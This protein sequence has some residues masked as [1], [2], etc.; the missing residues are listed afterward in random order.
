MVLDTHEPKKALGQHWLYDT[1]V[2][3]AMCDAVSLAPNDKVLEIGPGLG[4]LTAR[5]LQGGAEVLALEYDH[6]LALNLSKNTQKLLPKE[7]S[8]LLTRLEVV[9]G[10]IRSF[11]LT[12]IPF[13]Y[14]LC[15]NI[16]Y[17]LTSNLIRILCDTS[18]QPWEAA[19]LMQKEVAERIVADDG[20]MSIISCIA[21]FYYECYGGDTVPAE[22]FTPPPKVNSQVLIMRRR[23]APL[24]A[25]NTKQF[26]RLIKAGYSEKR[27]NVRNAL[28]G[29]LG[30]SREYVEEHLDQAGIA[31]SER[32]ENLSLADWKKLFDTGLVDQL[33]KSA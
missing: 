16:P 30:T 28:S 10:D 33:S 31:H 20:K 5:L 12:K 27:K 3:D 24:F 13:G 32:A 7:S 2:L 15:A 9:E 18:N 6:E 11:D 14:K 1:D 19:L 17:Y 25:V 4:T 8:E 22:L 26:F 23:Q 29:G 21:Q